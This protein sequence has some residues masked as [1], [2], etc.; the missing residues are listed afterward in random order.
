MKTT[1]KITA[2]TAMAVIAGMSAQAAE[3]GEAAGR[4]VTVCMEG[5][6]LDP[7]VALRAREMA[8]KMF[9]GVGVTLDWRHNCPADSIRISLSDQSLAGRLPNAFAYALPYEGT[10]IVI[11]YDRVEHVSQ[12]SRRPSL[13]AHVLVHEITHILQG[14][15]RHSAEGVMKANWDGGDYS[16]MTWKPLAFTPE[17]IVLLHNGLARRS[18]QAN[19]PRLTANLENN[20]ASSAT[21]Q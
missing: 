6:S 5:A 11:F 19:L 18:A 3:L 16:A 4:K 13:L 20:S 8:S 10:H 7:S 17:D 14:V 9:S 12:P 2:M 21:L 15:E 1:A